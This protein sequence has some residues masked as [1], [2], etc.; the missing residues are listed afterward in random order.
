[1]DAAHQALKDAKTIAVVGLDSRTNRT[2]YAIA[3]YLQEQG[4]KIIPVHRGNFPADEVLGEKAYESLRDVP[5][6]ID[7]VDVFVR[8][9]QTE[10]VIED[11][12]AVHAGCVWLQ[13]GIRNND[14]LERARAAGIAATQ[15]ICTMVEHRS[16]PRR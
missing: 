12:I 16:L 9:E 1:M 14:G 13:V 8:S 5:G 10:S 15:D 6:H 2:A 4:Y 11:A 7:L 3:S